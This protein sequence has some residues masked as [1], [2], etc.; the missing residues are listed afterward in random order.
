MFKRLFAALRRKHEVNVASPKD[1]GNVSVSKEEFTPLKFEKTDE[2][3]ELAKESVAEVQET[4][5][6]A[7][8]SQ[9][10]VQSVSVA[11][12]PDFKFSSV[13]NVC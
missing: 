12:R 2:K 13:I 7:G 9:T 8:V 11:I 6:A 3:V 5:I 10:E 1:A 4:S